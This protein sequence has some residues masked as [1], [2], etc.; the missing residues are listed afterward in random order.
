MKYVET[1]EEL[2]TVYGVAVAASLSK[3]A[4]HLTQEYGRW[5]AASKF[6]IV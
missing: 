1:V 3:V 4:D 5:V 2:E 6:C